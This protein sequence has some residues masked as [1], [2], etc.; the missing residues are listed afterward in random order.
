[1]YNILELR[2]KSQDELLRIAQELGVKKANSLAP[3]ALVYAILDQQAIVTS[4]DKKDESKAKKQRARIA[5]KV[6]TEEGGISVIEKTITTEPKADK[7]SVESPSVVANTTPKEPI[8]AEK[9][10]EV[11][12]KNLATVQQIA[13]TL[14]EHMAETEVLLRSIAKDYSSEINDRPNITIRNKKGNF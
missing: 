14:G 2:S 5:K 7:K 13:C 10:K 9:A 3:D 12:E 1:M 6:V 11:I 4:V 8:V